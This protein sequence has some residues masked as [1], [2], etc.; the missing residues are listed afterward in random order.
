[1]CMRTLELT[2][3]VVKNLAECTC[4]T[5]VISTDKFEILVLR[6]QYSE[7]KP[8][9]GTVYDMILEIGEHSDGD[10]SQDAKMNLM[11]YKKIMAIEI[12]ERQ[13]L[14]RMKNYTKKE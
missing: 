14:V 2:R 3:D 8:R 1:M 5:L 4:G 10:N 12:A 13:F 11:E 6:D 7:F 9:R